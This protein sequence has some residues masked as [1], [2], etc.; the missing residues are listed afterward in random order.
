MIDRARPVET[1]R[2]RRVAA[3]HGDRAA[4]GG[5]PRIGGAKEHDDGRPERRGEV[6]DAGVAAGEGVELGEECHEEIGTVA[7]GEARRA[8]RAPHRL[9]D[10]HVARRAEQDRHVPARTEQTAQLHGVTTSCRNLFTAP[11]VGALRVQASS[12]DGVR[13]AEGTLA[14]AAKFAGV[15]NFA[16]LPASSIERGRPTVYITAPLW[17]TVAIV[18]LFF[19]LSDWVLSVLAPGI[20][21]RRRLA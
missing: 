17:L 21:A 14:G 15:P 9:H 6:G 12:P 1:R 4:W 19:A 16:T 7:P 5:E 10:R 13:A 2:A 18:M 20:R 3:N 11:G 8:G